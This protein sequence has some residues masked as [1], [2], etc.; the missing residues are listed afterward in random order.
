MFDIGTFVDKCRAAVEGGVDAQAIVAELVADAIRHPSAIND[1]L[2][3]GGH[4]GP[5]LLHRSEGLT[6]YCV[7]ARPGES[8]PPHDHLLWSVAGLCSGDEVHALYVRE[9]ERVVRDRLVTLTGGDVVTLDEQ[10]VHS[11]RDAGS[12]PAVALHVYGGDL[13]SA[14]RSAWDDAG[15][16]RT[17]LGVIEATSLAEA[18]EHVDASVRRLRDRQ[19]T[20]S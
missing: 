10:A 5:H 16:V 18:Q 9:D 17:P 19:A 2:A 14:P 11:S 3:Q 12:S 1:V 6:V 8:V 4:P 15:L 13:F 7:R 20:T